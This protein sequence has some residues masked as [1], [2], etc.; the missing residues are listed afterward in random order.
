MIKTNRVSFIVAAVFGL[1][2]V[3]A[4]CVVAPAETAEVV[5]QAPPDELARLKSEAYAASKAE[6]EAEAKTPEEAARA[7]NDAVNAYERLRRAEK[8]IAEKRSG[9]RLNSLFGDH[10]VLQR[11]MPI[12]VWGYANPHTFVTVLFRGITVTAQANEYGRFRLYLPPQEA[13][14]PF[15]MQVF[16]D[17]ETLSLKDIYI[18]EVWIGGGQSNMEMPLTGYG[19]PVPEADF[20]ALTASVPVRMI[21]VEQCNDFTVNDNFKAHWMTSYKGNEGVW[22]ATAGFF[23]GK[24]ARE[25]KVP[26]GI[27]LC[28]Y[29]GSRADAWMSFG[30]LNRAEKFEKALTDYEYGTRPQMLEDDN[31]FGY[32]KE[33]GFSHPMYTKIMKDGVA[34]YPKYD[35]NQGTLGIEKPDFDDSEWKILKVPGNWR[36]RE[37]IGRANGIVWYRKAVEIPAEWAGK[38][39]TLAIGAVDKQDTT[40]FNGVK[41]G[42]TGKGFEYEYWGTKRVYR[43]PANL[44][45]AGKAIIAVRAVS[46]AD[47]GGMFG[48]AEDM[49]LFCPEVAGGEI[50]LS[51]EWRGRMTMNIDEREAGGRVYRHMPHFL[52]DSMLESV[53]PYAAR[54]AIWYQGESNLTGAGDYANL[55]EL[56]IQDW[57][58]R[59]N[60]KDFAFI[61]VIL[62]GWDSRSSQGWPEQRMRQIAAARATGTGYV[63]AT[64]AGHQNIHPPYKKVVGDRLALRALTDVYSRTDLVSRG[65]EAVRAVATNDTVVVSF[66]FAQGLKTAQGAPVGGVEVAGKT[67]HGRFFKA[68]AKVDGD[69]LVVSKPADLKND[70]AIL[71]VRYAWHG[72]PAEAN[73]YN[74]A[75]LPVI[76]FDIAVE[77]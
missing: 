76:P 36:D 10:A 32:T 52:S 5:R 67:A 4:G 7:R 20:P 69:R 75:D 56:L 48:P 33:Y 26:V 25:L 55:M 72:Y 49:K 40:Y 8:G 30:A 39:L 1:L 37:Q 65:P 46:F 51:G 71:R 61:Q 50:G 44:V 15:T 74:A 18:G 38:E 47:A 77:K 62:A 27:V 13:G 43:I 45:K 42:E 35:L 53:I 59:W 54:G 68:E 21:K 3:V 24:L 73:L 57:R 70:D 16:G 22:S 64:D 58:A 23:A 6:A 41:I 28:S 31:R 29:S 17:N 34:K 9:L 14:G 66:D 11:E 63:S 2:W 19:V 60:Q 12:P